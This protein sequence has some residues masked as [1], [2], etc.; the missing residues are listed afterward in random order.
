MMY[1]YSSFMTVLR[2]GCRRGSLLCAA[3]LCILVSTGVVSAQQNA[4]LGTA[5]PHPSSLLDMTSTT[6]GLLVPRMTTL[7]RTAINPPA[8]GLLVFDTDASR[9]YFYNAATTSWTALPVL[10]DVPSSGGTGATWSLTGNAGI[11]SAAQFLGTTDAQPLFI[12]TNG[13]TRATVLANGNVGI[14]TSAPQS[15]LEISS[16]GSGLRFTNLT[17]ATPTTSGTGK[18]LSVNATGDVVLVDD[19]QGSGS[20]PVG[21]PAGATLRY[22]GTNWVTSNTLINTG[23]QI[24]IS[25][26]PTRTL[27]VNGNVRIGVSGTTITNVIKVT[28]TVTSNIFILPENSTT[29]TFSVPGAALGSS[30]IVS[31]GSGMTNGLMIAYSR[32]SAANTVEVRISNILS[33]VAITLPGTDYYITVIE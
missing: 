30:V 12:R 22:N 7:Q 5:S 6:Q 25:T 18:V 24:G 23:T 14:G 4:G 32:V 27:D 10:A 17:A 33:S 29:L 31:P 21:A 26:T 16:T 19:A 2:G 1:L 11:N 28:A 15:A 20:L 3:F 9:F 8:N 13:S